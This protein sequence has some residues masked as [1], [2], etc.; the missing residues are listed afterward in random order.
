MKLR[1]LSLSLALLLASGVA[2]DAHAQKSTRK[3]A[4][5]TPSYSQFF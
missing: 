1:S 3:P 4:A 5:D 2:A